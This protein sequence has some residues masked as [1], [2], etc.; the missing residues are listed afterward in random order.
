MNGWWRKRSRRRRAVSVKTQIVSRKED[1][2]TW[3]ILV[4]RVPAPFDLLPRFIDIGILST[5]MERNSVRNSNWTIIQPRMTQIFF[6]PYQLHLLANEY[7][8]VNLRFLV[9]V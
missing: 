6:H 7:D 5:G 2:A 4:A 3:L 8:T 1:V 9:F